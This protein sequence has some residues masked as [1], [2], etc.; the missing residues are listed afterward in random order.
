[1]LTF[2]LSWP[3]MVIPTYFVVQYQGNILYAWGSATA[4]IIAMAVCFWLRFRTGKWKSM[5]VIETTI[6]PDASPATPT[7]P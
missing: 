2:L 3:I 6:D 1:M 7:I 4:F 5:R